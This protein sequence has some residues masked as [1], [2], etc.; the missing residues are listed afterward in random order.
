MMRQIQFAALNS[1]LHDLR[2]EVAEYEA[3]RAGRVDRLTFASFDE[4]G[5]ALIK[6]RIAAGLT[7]RQLAE[8]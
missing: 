2:T 8:R 7:Q 1:Q 6:A 5:P 3:L 4:I